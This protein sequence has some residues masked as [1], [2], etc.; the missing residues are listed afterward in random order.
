LSAA[1][2]LFSWVVERP[3]Q[4]Y[5]TCYV[6][7]VCGLAMTFQAQGKEAE[8]CQVVEAAIAFLLETGNTT[9]LPI[10]LAL[11]AEVAFR[12]RHLPAAS[13]WA[14][15]LDPVPPLVP[16]SWFL[17]PHLTLVKVWLAQNT[18]VSQAK[19]TELLNQLLEYLAGIHNTRF[20]IETLAL[21]ALHLDVLGDQL[22]ALAAL[23]KALQL[24]Q[25][26]GFI[27]VFVD[28]GPQM[29]ALLSSLKA[30]KGLQAY[31]EQIR[32]A[33]PG[34]QPIIQAEL[35]EPLTNRELQILKLLSEHLTNKEISAQLMISPATVKGHTIKIYQKLD[36]KGRRQAVEK[37]IRIGI[38]P[39]K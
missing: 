30:N 18:L 13:Q 35:L 28:L 36:V 12:Q 11:Q 5:D 1:E 19:A 15:K 26:G 34:S 6:S 10:I 37:A 38:L 14:V 27:R 31:V 29:A 23:E 16:M 24:A 25:P 2:A 39:P 3:Y 33:F 4:N 20:M 22:A 7:S 17:S 9:Q 32:S 8:A 21:Q